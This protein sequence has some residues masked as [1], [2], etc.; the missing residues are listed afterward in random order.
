MAAK[1]A[2]KLPHDNA[3][4][5]GDLVHAAMPLV[6]RKRHHCHATELCGRKVKNVAELVCT[7][8][9]KKGRER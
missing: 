3:R 8:Q 1:L 5:G 7:Q 6:D 2:V 4:E 9:R